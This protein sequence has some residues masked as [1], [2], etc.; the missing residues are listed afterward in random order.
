MH[1]FR[2]SFSLGREIG[3]RKHLADVL[4]RVG[5]TLDKHGRDDASYLALKAAFEIYSSLGVVDTA[6]VASRLDH[7][8][9][10]IGS[11]AIERIEQ[12]AA[13]LREPEALLARLCDCAFAA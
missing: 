4:K 13:G 9:G 12:R 11:E 8:R 3:E 6:E 10:T 5:E 1:S 7:L 2:Q